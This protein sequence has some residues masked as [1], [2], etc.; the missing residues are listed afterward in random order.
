[1]LSLE[2]TGIEEIEIDRKKK[3]KTLNY[4]MGL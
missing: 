4:S 3:K 1:M 2:D